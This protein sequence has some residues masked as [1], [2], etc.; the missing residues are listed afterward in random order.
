MS[1]EERAHRIAFSERQF[2]VFKMRALR[3]QA[4]VLTGAYKM[5]ESSQGREPTSEE[6]ERGVVIGWTAHTEEQKLK[7]ALDTMNNFIHL[8]DECN[9]S[10]DT[11]RRE[12]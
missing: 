4:I 9:E 11:L 8:M 12:E 7:I 3:A 10:I 1:K 5:R 6:K 2:E